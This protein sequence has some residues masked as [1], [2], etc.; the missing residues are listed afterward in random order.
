VAS[1]EI[2]VGTDA[3]RSLIREGKSAQVLNLMQTGKQYGM[4]TLEDQLLKAYEEGLI[5]SDNCI[6][7]ANRPDDVRRRID[8]ITPKK[9]V[10]GIDSMGQRAPA[11]AGVAGS[12]AAGSGMSDGGT[13]GVEA[14]DSPRPRPAVR[15]V[16]G[17]R[18]QSAFGDASGSKMRRPQRRT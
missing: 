18:P 10:S 17:G 6:A 5:T 1:R 14:S 4:C 13:P 3:V 11:T 15:G 12:G 2:L 16:T 9:Q 7:K 8:T